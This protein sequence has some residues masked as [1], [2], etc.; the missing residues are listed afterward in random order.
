MLFADNVQEEM[1]G[2]VVGD[3]KLTN[4]AMFIDS[5]ELGSGWKNVPDKENHVIDDTTLRPIDKPDSPYVGYGWYIK[6]IREI[7]VDDMI[8]MDHIFSNVNPQDTMN[9]Y[10]IFSECKSNKCR[11][12]PPAPPSYIGFCKSVF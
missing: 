3:I 2:L 6:H 9:I 12:C 4:Q 5:Y 11:P 7:K 1:V 8:N 10:V